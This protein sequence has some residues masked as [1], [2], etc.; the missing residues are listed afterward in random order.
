MWS[1]SY[2]NRL[3]FTPRFTADVRSVLSRNLHQHRLWWLAESRGGGACWPASSSLPASVLP[4]APTQ[5][6]Q[7]PPVS[8]SGAS[9]GDEGWGDRL[10]RDEQYGTTI[11]H[12]TTEEGGEGPACIFFFL[13]DSLFLFYFR[14]K[15]GA[16]LPYC[17]WYWLCVRM[18]VSLWVGV[19]LLSS[20]VLFKLFWQLGGGDQQSNKDN[21]TLFLLLHHH[22]TLHLSRQFI[23]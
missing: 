23:V 5:K 14:K 9:W 13:L 7:Q 3:S 2:F 6:A 12:K 4:S 20:L 8:P 21:S 17:S 11:A 1:S 18:E 15:N 22:Q 19:C 10:T 16:S